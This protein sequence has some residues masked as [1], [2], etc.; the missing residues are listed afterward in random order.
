[1][2]PEKW[3]LLL[4]DYEGLGFIVGDVFLAGGTVVILGLLGLRVFRSRAGLVV[5]FAAAGLASL[6]AF[7]ALWDLAS[8]LARP[9][10]PPNWRWWQGL[11]VR[12]AL[13]F[14]PLLLFVWLAPV[15]QFGILRRKI[16]GSKPHP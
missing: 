15:V 12:F 9:D 3:Q 13:P 8:M 16:R 14:I 7:S 1:M 5:G 11:N 2:G 6:P 4:A 10:L